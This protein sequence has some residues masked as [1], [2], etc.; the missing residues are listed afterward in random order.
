MIELCP[1][2]CS[3]T[4]MNQYE[5]PNNSNKM[6]LNGICHPEY[7][8]EQCE[9][10]M[11]QNIS[12]TIDNNNPHLNAL[13]AAITSHENGEN[14]DDDVNSIGN[15]TGNEGD[16]EEKEEENDP[17]PH[18]MR[19]DVTVFDGSMNSKANR[20]KTNVV[21]YYCCCFRYRSVPLSQG[22][23]T[24]NNNNDTNTPVTHN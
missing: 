14:I 4:Y 13:Q 1:S 24:K 8:I 9:S 23:H 21:S 18:T 16:E 5:H 17:S 10:I 2:H 19:T 6:T 20:E 22:D 15:M 11:K 3:E 12:T 7:S